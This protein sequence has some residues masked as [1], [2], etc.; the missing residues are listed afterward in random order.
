M[1][2]IIMILFQIKKYGQVNRFIYKSVKEGLIDIVL[3]DTDNINLNGLTS[4]T[5]EASTIITTQEQMS[6]V[7][8]NIWTKIKYLEYLPIETPVYG[9]PYLDCG[10][11]IIVSDTNNIEYNTFI[12]NQTFTFDGGFSQK[13]KNR[14]TN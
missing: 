12:F 5:I 2:I 1:E 13:L 4:L 11:K 8:N 9:F 7:A 14:S 6:S 3:E 10:D